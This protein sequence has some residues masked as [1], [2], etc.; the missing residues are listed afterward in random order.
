[1]AA[2]SSPA[3]P[4]ITRRYQP[5]A[6]V[7]HFMVMLLIQLALLAWGFR[8][9]HQPGGDS[10]LPQN[11]NVAPFYISVILL[12]WALVFAVW[13][14]VK[15][16][17][18]KIWDLVGD[19]WQSWKDVAGDV[20]ICIPFVLVWEGTAWAIHRMLGPDSAKSIGTLLPRT[21]LEIG[22]WIAISISAG[23]CEEIVFRGYFQ[24]QF[25]AYTNSVVAAVVLQGIVFGAGHSYQGV[26][27]VVVISVLGMLYGW[28]AAWRRN[29]RINMMSHAW[30]DIWS[31][32]LSG[33][34]R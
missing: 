16:R 2:P 27:Q 28:L 3:S 26:K 8:L 17:G 7:R 13:R 4:I 11:R 25:T 32:W 6:S 21:A 23:V 9:Q 14:G 20:A 34:L 1:M 10:V 30:S 33:V 19:R 5:V 12:E 29:L 15:L 22:L 18:L 31:G 24:K